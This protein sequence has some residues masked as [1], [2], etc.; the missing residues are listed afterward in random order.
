[1]R[2]FGNVQYFRN[3]YLW[4]PLLSLLGEIDIHANGLFCMKF[5][6]EQ[7]LFEEIFGIMRIF[8]SVRP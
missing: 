2:V 7:R 5:N 1:M 6:S 3:D 8:G 4:S